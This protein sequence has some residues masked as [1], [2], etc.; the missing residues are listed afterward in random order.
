MKRM[1]M[2]LLSLM[3]M[4]LLVAPVIVHA[5]EAGIRF[6]VTVNKPNVHVRVGNTPTGRY[7]IYQRGRLPVRKLTLYRISIRDRKIAQRLARYTGVPAREL[8]Q[9]R[10]RGYTWLEIGCWLGLPRRVVLAAGHPQSWN[11]FLLGERRLALR[12][13]CL[14][15]PVC[16]DD[17]FCHD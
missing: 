15:G 16:P 12:G 14:V 7:R 9:L 17:C 6:N 5:A 10:H 8:V 4:A 2:S 3:A 13:A 1:Q 11:R